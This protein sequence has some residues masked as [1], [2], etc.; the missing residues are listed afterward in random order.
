MIRG[1]NEFKGYINNIGNICL[2][3][4]TMINRI[5]CRDGIRS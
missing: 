5:K 1:I 3:Q 4:I 2:T